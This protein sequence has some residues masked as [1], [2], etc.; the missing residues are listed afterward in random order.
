MTTIPQTD[1][2]IYNNGSSEIKQLESIVKDKYK[3]FNINEYTTGTSTFLIL[4]IDSQLLMAVY[5]TVN[6]ISTIE[7][8]SKKCMIIY[9]G[10]FMAFIDDHRYDNISHTKISNNI[11]KNKCFAID[12]SKYEQYDYEYFID[13]CIKRLISTMLKNRKSSLNNVTNVYMEHCINNILCTFVG[14]FDTNYG[15]RTFGLNKKFEMFTQ[16]TQKI[17]KDHVISSNFVKD[18]FCDIRNVINN[19][20]INNNINDIYVNDYVNNVLFQQFDTICKNI[21][22]LE[23]EEYFSFFEAFYGYFNIVTIIDS[24]MI[25]LQI[26]I[27]NIK[28]KY[29]L[30]K[31]KF[32]D[33]IYHYKITIIFDYINYDCYFG[34]IN[35]NIPIYNI[36]I[37][38][39]TSTNDYLICDNVYGYSKI[40]NTISTSIHKL[41]KTMM[42]S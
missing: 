10:I 35:S 8:K 21:T 7:Y 30:T 39:I 18:V 38:D 3:Y 19:H 34:F 16:I 36:S 32:N 42:I 13:I 25:I 41:L 22:I 20:I 24:G 37:M 2:T 23:I 40:I 14:F 29:G 5:A 26:D 12:P 6:D 9:D 15:D 17:K 27:D 28:Y 4:S 1:S 11:Y 31:C 33:D